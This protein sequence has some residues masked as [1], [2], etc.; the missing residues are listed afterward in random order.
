MKRDEAFTGLEAAL[1]LLA[2]IVVASVFSYVILGAGY[3]SIQKSQSVI[4]SAV[5]QSS[6]S[7]MIEGD[8]YGLKNSTSGNIDKIRLSIRSPYSVVPLDLNNMNIILMKKD[9]ITKIKR[10]S[11]VLSETYPAP[12]YWSVIKKDEESSS[13]SMGES[14]TIVISL[15][16]DLELKSNENFKIDLLPSLGASVSLSGS[17]PDNIHDTNILY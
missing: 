14:A 8:V 12:G 9:S 15:T 3:F 6:S 16:E 11:P 5:E 2:F 17:V 13:L 1:V 4:Y 7:F 10:S